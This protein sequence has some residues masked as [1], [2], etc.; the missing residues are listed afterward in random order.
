MMR[1][2]LAS[3]V[4]SKVVLTIILIISITVV[5]SSNV[6]GVEKVISNSADW[7]DVYSM[8]LY[9]SLIEK[10]PG[11]FLTSTKHGTI[12]LY[13]IPQSTNGTLIISSRSQ[14]YTI[15]YKSVMES[16]GYND[17]EEIITNTANLDLAKRLSEEN[18]I[19][20]FI[21]VD[22]AYG[23]NALSA[24]SYAVVDK[25]Y[26]LFVNGRNIGAI[27]NFL[28]DINPQKIIILG[29]VEETVKTR[30]SKYNPEIINKGDRFDNNI[31]MVKKYMQ[32]KAAKQVLMSNG[33]FIEASI[34]SGD[35]PVLFIGKGSVPQQV[36][37]YIKDT[38]I[39]V[40]VLIGNE[41]INSATAIRRELGISVFVKF[42]QGSRTPTGPIATVE[43]LDKFPMPT[44]GVNIE[45]YSIMYN[46]ATNALWVTYRNTV[47]IGAYLKG[48]ITLTSGAERKVVGDEEPIFIDKNQYKTITYDVVLEEENITAKL[49]TLF[50]EGKRS[51]EN[52]LEA[53]LQVESVEILDSSR[54]NITNVEYDRNNKQFIISVENI[55]E[56]DSYVSIEAL[57]L[58]VNGEYIT[59]SSPNAVLIK[60]GKNTKIYLNVDLSDADIE[61]NPIVKIKGYYGERENSLIKTTYGE[62]AFKFK[63]VDYVTY[64]LIILIVILLLLIIFKGKK[65]K[66]CKHKNSLLRKTCK[67][68]GQPLYRKRI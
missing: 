21:I 67:K 57:D 54:I 65:C 9:S 44:Y 7:R 39:Q 38:D 59:V 6:I 27:D 34:M 19:K 4:I 15:N 45:I 28:S 8:M 30:L 22:D 68:C 56:V 26:V 10:Q 55:G 33:E 3:T 58:Y 35:N 11:A 40:A 60:A 42:A 14:P 66:N 24:A 2:N 29:Q 50:G 62:Y 46:K 17:V 18:N 43:D 13:S 20:K 16:Q 36:K 49:Y 47:S 37:D 25:H 51:L 23:Y 12:L 63:S 52:I 64:G 48:T 61:S 53:E 32:V 1:G 41:L 5:S 31:E